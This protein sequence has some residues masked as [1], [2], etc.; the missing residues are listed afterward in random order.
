[1][2]QVL[3]IVIYYCFALK[4]T[5]YME[6][7]KCDLLIH[8][9]TTQ[10]MLILIMNYYVTDKCKQVTANWVVFHVF[11]LISQFPFDLLIFGKHIM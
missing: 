1:M 7:V 5:F 10:T 2:L 6:Y 8:Y 4:Y 3:Y 11:L 9:R